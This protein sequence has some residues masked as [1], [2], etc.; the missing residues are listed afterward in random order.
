MKPIFKLLATILETRSQMKISSLVTRIPCVLLTIYLVY[1]TNSQSLYAQISPKDQPVFDKILADWQTRFKAVKSIEY[2]I[3]LVDHSSS[4]KKSDDRKILPMDEDEDEILSKLKNFDNFPKEK[5]YEI[6]FEIPTGKI[7][8]KRVTS[9]PFYNYTT[10]WDGKYITYI[11][12]SEPEKEELINYDR[13]ISLGDSWHSASPIDL[14][15]LPVFAAHGI[16]ALGDEA[17]LRINNLKM[18]DAFDDVRISGKATFNGKECLIINTSTHESLPSNYTECWVDP[19]KQSSVTRF[20][21]YVRKKPGIDIQ[22][23]YQNVNDISIPESWIYV[24]YILGSVRTTKY[25]VESF[26]I[27]SEISSD[28]FFPHLKSKEKICYTIMPPLDSNYTVSSAEFYYEIDENLK[29]NLFGK[30]GFLTQSGDEVFPE[31]NFDWIP[32]KDTPKGSKRDWILMISFVFTIL[33]LISFLVWIS[34][35]QNNLKRKNL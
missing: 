5:R 12:P 8:I 34:R 32:K 28:V 9:N 7:L 27:N 30:R 2:N 21:D 14:D 1:L 25:K 6:I 23:N 10:M 11:S 16:F 29:P 15:I 26:R 17:A 20:I 22:I 33:L 3:V 31:E 35:R 18:R 13:A 19:L 24:N 4:K